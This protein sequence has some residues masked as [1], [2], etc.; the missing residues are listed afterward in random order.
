MLYICLMGRGQRAS[1]KTVKSRK[2]AKSL[3]YGSRPI[4]DGP[5][6]APELDLSETEVFLEGKELVKQLGADSITSF[7]DAQQDAAEIWIIA[8]SQDIDNFDIDTDCIEDPLNNKEVALSS[9]VKELDGAMEPLSSNASVYVV[10]RFDNF[11]PGSTGQLD[12][13]TSA[14]LNK[15]SV[16]EFG[17][18]VIR[19]EVPKGH[20]HIWLGGLSATESIKMLLPKGS[21]YEVA[22][23]DRGSKFLRV[24]DSE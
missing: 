9:V 17:D 16:S 19:A 3:L 23:D 22:V 11:S 15:A 14:G 21:R 13:V 10:N 1:E 2:E 20:K 5:K 7:N 24:L 8:A 12:Q 6:S 18:D 4:G